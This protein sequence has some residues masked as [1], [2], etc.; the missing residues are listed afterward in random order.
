MI[1]FRSVRQRDFSAEEDR[2][3]SIDD[4]RQ[5]KRK[6]IGTNQ[7]LKLLKQTSEQVACVFIARD[8][9][10]RVVTPIADLAEK[11]GVA[12]IWVDTM[13]Q[14][15]KACGIEVGAATAGIVVE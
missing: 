4:I 15:G 12:V 14:L 7:T 11:S 13:R 8:A 6:T 9:E 2:A 10:T 3:V 5:A 1:E